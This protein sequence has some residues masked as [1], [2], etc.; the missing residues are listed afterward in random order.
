VPRSCSQEPFTKLGTE[1]KFD[2]RIEQFSGEGCSTIAPHD[3][4]SL[5]R[6]C[7]L[8]SRAA[9]RTVDAA[10]LCQARPVTP[11]LIPLPPASPH[12]TCFQRSSSHRHTPLD[13]DFKLS[14]VK[15]TDVSANNNPVFSR[16][17]GRVC[18]KRQRKYTIDKRLDCELRDSLNFA[19]GQEIRFIRFQAYGLFDLASA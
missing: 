18:R 10:P 13:T 17:R 5:G 7:F 2:L 6:F 3:S 14:L 8:L 9:Q 11:W 1:P 12:S 19:Q 4:L 15:A 16:R